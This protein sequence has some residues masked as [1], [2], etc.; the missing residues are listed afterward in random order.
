MR[1]KELYEF[2]NTLDKPE[3]EI[4]PHFTLELDR[5]D[6][7]GK[8]YKDNCYVIGLDPRLRLLFSVQDSDKWMIVSETELKKFH[9]EH[10]TIMKI[11]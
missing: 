9:E 2:C 3:R 6:K 4:E 7:N 1:K 10:M 11:F 5:I 8:H